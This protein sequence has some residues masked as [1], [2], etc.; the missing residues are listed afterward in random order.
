MFTK[1]FPENSNLD[2]SSISLPSFTSRTNL[3]LHNYVIVKFV[4]N[5]IINLD[6]SKTSGPDCIPLVILK[7]HV[8][9]NFHIYKLNCSVCVKKNLFHAVGK[10]DLWSLHL[11]ILRRGQWLKATILLVFF[12]WLIKYLKNL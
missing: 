9:L 5:V 3:K 4:K 11:R 8:S 6:F 1:D 7:K 10:F 2:N 12:L